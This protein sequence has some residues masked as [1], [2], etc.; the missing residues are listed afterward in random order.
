MF[1][2]PTKIQHM[3]QAFKDQ[4]Q[5]KDNKQAQKAEEKRQKQLQKEENQRLVL[6]RT[7]TE[8]AATS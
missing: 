7:T 5:E 4:T 2:S 6:Q 3:Q 1:F 8:R